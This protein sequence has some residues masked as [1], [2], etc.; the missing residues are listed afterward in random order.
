MAKPVTN[1][2]V[3]SLLRSNPLEEEAYKPMGL[4]VTNREE[5]TVAPSLSQIEN[6]VKQVSFLPLAILCFLLRRLFLTE[7]YFVLQTLRSHFVR[8]GTAVHAKQLR[9]LKKL[10]D[11]SVRN[12]RTQ[13][14][15]QLRETQYQDL[16]FRFSSIVWEAEAA[17]DE[18]LVKLGVENV[19]KDE[20]YAKLSAELEAVHVA[21]L[22]DA[23]LLEEA[24]K[25]REQQVSRFGHFEETC[26]QLRLEVSQQKENYEVELEGLRA[27]V[28][29]LTEE[30]STC[31][32]E[33]AAVESQLATLASGVFL[34]PVSQ[35]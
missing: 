23:A 12:L 19:A 16:K 6:V 26:S 34:L 13:A 31:K 29:R 18:A 4:L 22:K 33:Q 28:Q 20:A 21:H 5:V 17:K 1:K 9:L 11:S 32:W 15:L 30:M 7:V 10:N 24:L 25:E 27:E 8:V 35:S 2:E 14:A 3:A